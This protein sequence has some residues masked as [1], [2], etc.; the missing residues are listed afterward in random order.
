M[1]AEIV[2]RLQFSFHPEDV[3]LSEFTT[4]ELVEE[5]MNRFPPGMVEIR[6][7]KVEDEAE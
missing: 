1:N 7:G 4:G 3:T 6:I 2:S 5:L